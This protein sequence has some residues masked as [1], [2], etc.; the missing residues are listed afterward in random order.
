MRLG[1]RVCST[2][3]ILATARPSGGPSSVAA[4]LSPRAPILRS[5]SS[6]QGVP[7]SE[8]VRAREAARAR[9]WYL[10]DTP[11]TPSSPPSPFTR[12]TP[13]SSSSSPTPPI[14]PQPRFTTF[15]PNRTTSTPS[16]SDPDSPLTPLPSFAPDHLHPL[17]AFLV[18]N[19]L[20]EPG[21]VQ[22]LHTPSSGVSGS[23]DSREVIVGDSGFEARWEWV[24]VCEVK[25]RG[26]GVVARAERSL[27]TWLRDNP[28]PKL[29]APRAKPPRIE[30]DTD[31]ALVPVGKDGGIC[32][33]LFTAEGRDRWALADLWRPAP[34]PQQ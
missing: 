2:C 31:W 24:G 29:S 10:N 32:V 15:D 19:E 12:S 20:I 21:T 28:V 23:E 3:R 16:S 4:R 30:P 14:R 18:A 11:S 17:H 1:Y 22:F 9:A 25:G 34:A 7:Q 26:K 13:S 8:E 27:R 6:S 33:N 5:S